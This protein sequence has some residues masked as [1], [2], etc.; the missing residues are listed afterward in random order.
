MDGQRARLVSSVL[1]TLVIA[2]WAGCGISTDGPMSGDPHAHATH[3]QIEGLGAADITD[4]SAVVSWTTTNVAAAVLRYST[5]SELQETLSQTTGLRTQHSVNLSEL[6][7]STTYYFMVNATDVTGDT[8]SAFGVPFET[9]RDAALNDSTPPVISNIEVVAVTSSSAEIHWET[10]DKTRGWIQYGL[11]FPLDMQA[12]EYPDDP[13]KYTCGHAIVLTGLADGTTYLFAV[14]AT[15]RAGLSTTESSGLSFTT[16]AAPTL[17]FCPDTVAVSPGEE[18]DLVVCITAA[19]DLAGIEL[20]IDFDQSAL[21]I[22]GDEAGVQEGPFL[23]LTPVPGQDGEFMVEVDP[24]RIKVSATWWIEYDASQQP[25]G[26]LA[27][28]DGDLLTI[29]C[30]LRE[31]SSRCD[32]TLI[33]YDANQDGKMDT[34]LYDYRGLAVGFHTRPGVVRLISAGGP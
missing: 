24:G 13:Y 1:L 17:G 34:R 3:L 31:G 5:D 7:P 4:T 11:A 26:T 16:L 22:V 2:I 32:L 27:D 19:Q 8:A 15:N 6:A 25:V 33:D 12:G 28:G 29:R 20:V 18:F 10:D 30:K 23:L 21:E 9:H 14:T